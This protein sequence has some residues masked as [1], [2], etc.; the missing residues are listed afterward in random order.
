MIVQ[1]SVEGS[2]KAPCPNSSTSIFLPV[3]VANIALVNCK[4]GVAPAAQEFAMG[5]YDCTGVCSDDA[6]PQTSTRVPVHTATC[7]TTDAGAPAEATVVHVS[8]RGS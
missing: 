5:S 2:Y 3:H 6:P 4:D 1:V 8:T 7:P